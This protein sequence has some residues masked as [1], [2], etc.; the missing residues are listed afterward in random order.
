[1]KEK[2]K[3]FKFFRYLF[4]K[5]RKK[6]QLF[7]DELKRLE[8][9]LKEKEVSFYFIEP[10][11]SFFIQGLSSFEKERLKWTFD[12]NNISSERERLKKIYGENFD[13]DYLLSVYDGAKVVDIGDHKKLVD[14][15]NDYVHIQGGIRFTTDTPPSATRKIHIFGACT[16]RGTG[17]ED[18]QTVA[19][20]LQRILNENNYSFQVVNHGIGCGSTPY[21]DLYAIKSTLLKSGDVVILMN[22]VSDS[23]IYYCRK[24]KL[25]YYES[26]SIFSNRNF[27]G[28]W[29]TDDTLHTNFLG[30]QKISE[31]VYQIIKNSL[32]ILPTKNQVFTIT[33]MENTIEHVKMN[34]DLRKYLQFLKE[35]NLNTESQKVGSIVMNCNPFTLGHRYLIETASKKVDI[36]IIFV[37]EEDKSFFP[38]E[39][40][41]NLVKKGTEDL[42]N[43]VVVPSGKFILSAV[44]FPG[45]FYKENDKNAT[46]DASND[47]EIFASLIAPALNI[48]VRFAG[49]EPLDFVTNQYNKYMSEILPMYGISFEVIERKKEAKEVIS[50][51]RVR[52]CI[53]END[54]TQIKKLVPKTTYDYLVKRFKND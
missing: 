8:T 34:E 39:D 7:F 36:L 23:S 6:N 12:F 47:I 53:K 4:F 52:K 1:M 27:D 10:P 18:S 41:I 28:E 16:V 50:A 26:S 15:Q 37:V 38:F 42:K 21:D 17:V 45:Y 49:E 11:K 35:L 32:N 19:S 30:N 25:P 9:E 22:S 3:R 40:R 14:F 2:L 5:I 46:I 33:S 43:V 48:T 54:Y 31:K 20:C 44:T 24:S 51:S 13:E 29:F